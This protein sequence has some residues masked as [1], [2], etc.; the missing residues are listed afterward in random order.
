VS[1]HRLSDELGVS[2]KSSEQLKDHVKRR[3]FTS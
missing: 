3:F 1:I 2:P